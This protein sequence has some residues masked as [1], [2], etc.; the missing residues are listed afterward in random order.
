MNYLKQSTANQSRILGP[1]VDDTDYKTFETGLTIANTSVKL[2]K[3][4]AASVDKNSGGGTHRVNGEYSLTFN[5]TDTDTVGELKVS[6]SVAGALPVFE[7]YFVLEEAVYDALFGASSVGPLTTLGANA[8]AN[9]INAAA[10]ASDAITAAKI[11]SDAITAAKIATGA[12]TNA[13]LAAGA[14]SATTFATAAITA[15][16]CASDF[17]GAAEIAA[18]ASAE[19]A[20][21]IAQDWI[22]GDASPLAIAAAVWA[23]SGR[24]LSTSPP[25]AEDISAAVSEKLRTDWHLMADG[26]D[27]TWDTIAEHI[28]I[29]STAAGV[30]GAAAANMTIG[31]FVGAA[32]AIAGGLGTG[33][34]PFEITLNAIASI[35]SDKISNDMTS[36]TGSWETAVL[37][38]AVL[39]GDYLAN[40]LAYGEGDYTAVMNRIA[41]AVWDEEQ[42][43]HTITGT[44]GFYL[45]VAISGVSGGGGDNAATIYTYFT[46]GTR[47]DAF[48]ATGFAVA[49]DAMTLTSDERN[50]LAGVIDS[51]LLNAG[52]ATDLI[53]G[54]VARLGSVDIDETSLVAAIKAALFNASDISNRLRVDSSGRVTVGSNADKTGYSLTTTPPTKQEIS[55]QLTTDITV[56]LTSL[57]E[58]ETQQVL[59]AI[60]NIAGQD[61]SVVESV[62]NAISVA[63]ANIPKFNQQIRRTNQAGEHLIEIIRPEV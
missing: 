53:A 59:S 29:S 19:I 16:A 58:Q 7:K 41:D 45:D 44:F 37:N 49:G 18:S 50:T 5:A 13:K 22:A 52:D 14:I 47:A 2:M 3:N 30:F 38:I 46:D 60:A 35:V 15:D 6:I 39:S 26:W 24:T 48:K 8:P 9:W 1:F 17:I 28:I 11:A 54:I 20:D 34:D 42:T 31:G 40:N 55:S 27:S 12:I 10:I 32:E 25:T 21:L 33:S 63:V 43:G 62:L 57:L 56:T 23:A 36:L 4:G 61:L 51:R